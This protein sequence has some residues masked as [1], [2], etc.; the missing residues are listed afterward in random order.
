MPPFISAARPFRPLILLL[1]AWLGL[2]TTASTAADTVSVRIETSEGNI[3]VALREDL[4]PKTVGNF[5]D[6]VDRDFYQGVIFH[7]VIP[8][9]MIQAGGFDA[10]MNRKEASDPVVN[11]SRPTARNLRGTLAMAR[12][13]DPDSATSQFFINLVDNA[14]LDARSDR[15]GYTVFGRVT[16]GMGVV[17]AIATTPTGTRNRMRDVPLDPVVIHRIERIEHQNRNQ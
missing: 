1:A 9:F 13:S 7:R 11:E 3:E 4:A 8:G 10:D 17:D 5:L 12:T 6:H 15:P 2:A 16:Q 14:Y